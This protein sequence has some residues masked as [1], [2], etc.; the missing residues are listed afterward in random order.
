RLAAK[1]ATRPDWGRLGRPAD[2]AVWRLQAAA[3]E[4]MQRWDRYERL[5]AKL[6]H[7]AAALQRYAVFEGQPPE[8]LELVRRCHALTADLQ[9]QAEVAA[10][11]AG[12]LDRQLQRLD[13]QAERLRQEYAA[14]AGLEERVVAAAREKAALL[15]Q[16]E[17]AQ[18]ELA[19]A[20]KEA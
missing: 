17:R 6:Q 19:R 13:A 11:R 7:T 12:D 16:R 5:R 18:A 14:V 4:A 15:E 20:E 3:G 8:V 1:L 9:R 10:A 2:E